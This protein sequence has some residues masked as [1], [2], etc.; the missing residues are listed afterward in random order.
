MS[1]EL[2]IELHPDVLS[3]I[4]LSPTFI[5]TCPLPRKKSNIGELVFGRMSCDIDVFYID[6]NNQWYYIGKTKKSTPHEYGPEEEAYHIIRNAVCNNKDCMRDE[7]YYEDSPTFSCTHL[8]Y[9][10]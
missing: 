10:L 6:S 9:Y 2:I 3:K 5:K 8:H 4:D 7:V 1:T